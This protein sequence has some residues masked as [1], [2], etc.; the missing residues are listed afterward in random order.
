MLAGLY[1]FAYLR[2]AKCRDAGGQWNE[3]TRVCDLPAAVPAGSAATTPATYL[4]AI[5]AGLLVGV[6]LWRLF[7]L[8][9]GEGPR[10]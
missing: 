8:S 10:R 5:L 2:S 3:V 7:R 9:K 6:M 1:T 4:L